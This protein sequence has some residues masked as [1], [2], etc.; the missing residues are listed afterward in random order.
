MSKAGLNARHEKHSF[1]PNTNLEW[2]FSLSSVSLLEAVQWFHFIQKFVTS[3]A[4]A[5]TKI[6][7]SKFSAIKSEFLDF[8]THSV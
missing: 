4:K 6:S 3:D 5:K 7:F 2:Q 1:Y 8:C